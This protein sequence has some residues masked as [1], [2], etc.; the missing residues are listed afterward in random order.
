ME[1]ELKEIDLKELVL[2][3]QICWGVWPEYGVDPDGN[4]IQTGFELSLAGVHYEPAHAPTP[5][6]SECVTVYEALERIA[7]WILPKE[8][9][10]SVYE[11]RI[12][13]SFSY[14]SKR[15][16]REEIPLAIKILHREGFLRPID[17]C[18]VKCLNE[19]QSKLTEIGARQGCW[20]A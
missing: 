17:A 19:M 2:K 8:E 10:E 20:R 6:C 15:K 3:H 1:K 18:E 13:P 7:K 9:R 4:R 14:S 16:Y 5:G 12:A 11:I